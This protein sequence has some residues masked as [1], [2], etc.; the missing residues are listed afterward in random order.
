MRMYPCLLP[1]LLRIG[2]LIGSY[3]AVGC[4]PF[5]QSYITNKAWATDNGTYMSTK[6]LR[7]IEGIPHAELP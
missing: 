3:E 2:M 5:L 4:S 1:S 6:I 7:A